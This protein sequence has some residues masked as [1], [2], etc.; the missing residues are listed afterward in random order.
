MERD[1]HRNLSGARLHRCKSLTLHLTLTA[2]PNNFGAFGL[3]QALRCFA[4]S[5]SG[6][7]QFK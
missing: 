5:V 2:Q 3:H 1:Q 7:R 4:E 6:E